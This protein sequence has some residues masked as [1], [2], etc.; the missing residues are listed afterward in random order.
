MTDQLQ[1]G[2]LCPLFKE[3]CKQDMC[4]AWDDYNEE[5]LICACMTKYLE[6]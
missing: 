5:C 1:K 6:S 4:Y 2:Y 3:M